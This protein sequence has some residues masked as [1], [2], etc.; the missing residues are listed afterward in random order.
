VK[1]FVPEPPRIAIELADDSLHE[2]GYQDRYDVTVT[3]DGTKQIIRGDYDYHTTVRLAQ[4]IAYGIHLV[5]G[6]SA[7]QEFPLVEEVFI[8]RLLAPKTIPAAA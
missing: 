6:V 3:M 4:G 7:F 1:T 8:H 5:S 2:S